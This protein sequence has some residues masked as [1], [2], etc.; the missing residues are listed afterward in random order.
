MKYLFD[1]LILVLIKNL[2]KAPKPENIRLF[3]INYYGS[4]QK[5]Y[6]FTV[7]KNEIFGFE[8]TQGRGTPC[9]WN[10]LNKNNYNL[11]ETNNLQFLYSTSYDFLAEQYKKELELYKQSSINYYPVPMVGGSEYYYKVYKAIGE[12]N[13]PQELKFTYSSFSNII[14]EVNVNIWICDE[15]YKDKCINNDTAK[16][17]YD[18]ETKKCSSKISCDKIT[19]ISKSNCENGITSTPSLTKCIYEKIN[20]E[21]KCTIK[22]LCVNSFSEEECNS[23]VPLNPIT[24][25][26]IY[27]EEEKICKE[28]KKYCYEINEEVTQDVCKN[29]EAFDLDKKCVFDK[30]NHCCKEIDLD[31]EDKGKSLMNMNYLLLILFLMI[32]I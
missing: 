12:G 7:F 11:T 20:E 27:D 22:N 10:D 6:E 13:Q 31:I 17:T 15:I 32:F 23:A 21:E 25:Y 5:F 16:C 14:T 30:E 4:K 18:I 1:F 8:F 9:N 24:S 2:I 19:N 29:A 28:E 26:C 3:P